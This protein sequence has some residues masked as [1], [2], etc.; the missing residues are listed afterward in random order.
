ME[1]EM[2]SRIDLWGLVGLIILLISACVVTTT[3]VLLWHI[4]TN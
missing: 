3:I 1:D 2:T 4:I